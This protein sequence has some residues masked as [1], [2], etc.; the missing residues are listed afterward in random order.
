[1]Y[2]YLM[3]RHS[4]RNGATTVDWVNEVEETRASY[5]LILRERD[6][7]HHHHHHHQTH[8]NP[9]KHATATTTTTTTTYVEVKTTRFDELNVFELSLWEWEFATAHPR[10]RYHIYRVYNAGDL[11]R[12]RI[13]VLEDVL[14]LI[15]ERRVKLCLA[16]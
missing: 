15:T 11:S 12:V 5:D 9:T 3:H 13:V 16:V 14:R 1:M 10:V 7:H 4:G 6:T 2:Q 8:A